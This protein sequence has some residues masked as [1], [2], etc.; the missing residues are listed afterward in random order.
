MTD[1]AWRP[2]PGRACRDFW[3]F[4]G[5][6]R[7]NLEVN[8]SQNF[9][10]GSQLQLNRRVRNMSG[11]QDDPA[12]PDRAKP[13]ADDA[14]IVLDRENALGVSLR[15]E[16]L[17]RKAAVNPNNAPRQQVRKGIRIARTNL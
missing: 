16:L 13:A 4:K 2:N 8:D 1:G 10:L 11:T 6:Q 7:T 12:I 3:R 9:R 14:A 15:E 17:G 5:C